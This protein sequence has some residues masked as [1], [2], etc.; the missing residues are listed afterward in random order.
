M[1]RFN[2]PR[3]TSGPVKPVQRLI[4]RDA[5]TLVELLVVI[6]VIALLIS[7][8]LPALGRARE[9]A[10]SVAC[11]SNLR[12][13]GQASLVYSNQYKGFVLPAGYR[14]PGT[15]NTSESFA[16]LLHIG[17]IL[18]SPLVN[19]GDPITVSSVWRCPSGIDDQFATSL[20]ATGPK[21][22]NADRP[23]R[24]F[25]QQLTN[26]AGKNT[27]ID[28]WYAMNAG[29]FFTTRYVSA[30]IPQDTNDNN[31][32]LLKATKL[33]GE[34]GKDLA[35]MHDGIWMNALQSSQPWRISPRHINRT[36]TNILFLDGHAESVA[37][38]QIPDTFSLPQDQWLSKWPRPRWRND[39]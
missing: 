12:Q 1:T 21:D 28:V 20:S 19:D 11:L 36:R 15:T 38:S 8:L 10:S 30:R 14:Q 16:S 13:I 34:R 25:S 6:G 22:L 4:F 7:I 9:A 5:F 37:R 33:I 24:A 39:W 32:T 2:R 17:G 26:D 31:Y 3:G 23:W 29:T 18:T 27:Y 35:F